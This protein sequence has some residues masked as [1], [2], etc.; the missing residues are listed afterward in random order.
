M[1]DVDSNIANC[2]TIFVREGFIKERRKCRNFH[3]KKGVAG[4]V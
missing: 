4:G 3:T 2:N 1:V